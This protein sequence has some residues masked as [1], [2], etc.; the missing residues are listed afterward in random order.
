MNGLALT[1][2]SHAYDRRAVVENVTLSVAPGETVCLLGPSGC[3]KTTLLRIAAGLEFLQKGE[4]RI[5]GAVVAV[6]GNA[7]QLPPERRGVGFMFQDYALF[8]H[9]TITENIRF[10]VAPRDD[11][12]RKWIDWALAR[13]GLEGYAEAYPHQLS[14]GQQQRVA[15][16]RALAPKPSVM[17][18]DEP[19]S[20]LDVALR[21]Q[22]RDDTLGLLKE[23]GVATLMVTHD[24][25]EAMFMADRIMVMNAG[26]VLQAGTPL[27]TYLKP[28]DAFVAE[29][30][31]PVNRVFGAVRSGRVETPLGTF[32]APAMAEDTAV[33]IL[34]RP[35]ALRPRAADSLG[36]HP[37][38][39]GGRPE[40]AGGCLVTM[41]VVDAHPVGAMSCVHLVPPDAAA[42]ILTARVPGIFLPA[43]GAPVVVDVDPERADTLS[44]DAAQRRREVF[45][46][47]I[48]TI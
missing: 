27:E 42:P 15:L 19:F 1:H 5:G 25:E 12:R 38:N 20:G 13:F 46:R 39:G 30:F 26:R 18:L 40:W 6:G 16:L 29:L 37:W 47:L 9:L 31:G 8:P 2:V 35:E 14:G 44:P 3:G 45:G 24:P 17:L 28:I 41:K 21:T 11:E 4:V 23:T 34:I 36:A 7:G 48:I 43:P 32:A 33:E 10:G 22:V